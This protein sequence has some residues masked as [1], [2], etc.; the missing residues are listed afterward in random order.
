MT[1]SL[2]NIYRDK[3]LGSYAACTNVNQN[4]IADQRSFRAK[5][6]QNGKENW[7]KK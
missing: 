5:Y 4:L 3:H 7:T 2:T 6:V 1:F